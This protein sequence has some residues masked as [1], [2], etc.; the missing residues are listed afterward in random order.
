MSELADT[1]FQNTSDGQRQRVLLASAICREPEILLLDEPTSYLDIRYKLD[2][3]GR[4][5]E[6]A[7]ERGIAVVMSLHELEI[8]M[9][10]SDHVIAIGNGKVLR[11][12]S[13]EEIFTEDFI[14]GLY[15][16]EG[17]DTALLGGDPW[18]RSTESGAAGSAAAEAEM[19]V[20]K[21]KRGTRVIMIQGT[22]SNAG[23]SV[24]AAGLCRIF[25]QDGYRVAPFKSQNMALNSC[26]TEEGLEMGRAQV[27]QAECA[28]IRPRVCMNPILLKP[29]DD[30][31]SQVI[32]N[33][34]VVGNM[35]A[36]EYFRRKKEFI[37]KIREA[38]EELSEDMDIIV[39]EGAGSPVE[40]NLKRDDI[41]NMGLAEMID[42]PVLL[43]GDI[44]RGGIFAQILGTLDLLTT[45]ERARVK[46]VIVNKFRGD[47]ALFADGIGIL[48][49]RG[50][51]RV[52][53]V[54]P[55]MDVHLDDEDSLSE[56]FKPVS[57]GIVDIAVIRFPHISNFTDPDT[58]E[59]LPEVSVRYV[60][61]PEALLSPDLILLPGTKNTIGDLRWLRTSGLAERICR[62]A[63][64][65]LPVI[66]ICGGYQMLGRRISDPDH[67]ECG[68]E[69]AGLDL[70]PADTVLGSEKI[71][72][73]FHGT[74]D[75]AT[76]MLGDLCGKRVSGYEI[77]MGRTAVDAGTTP[78]TSGGTGCC[79]DNI[80]GS[81]IH[82]LFDE[83][84]IT[85]TL[86]GALAG[87]KGKQVDMRNLLDYA[88][89]KETQYDL[90]AAHLREH[91][92]MDRIYEILGIQRGAPGDGT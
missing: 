42:A 81:Y 9:R 8:A 17:M 18:L 51:T 48:E 49:E 66:G 78:F 63:A 28:G 31:G 5:R 83:K 2:I 41:V 21:E 65:G 54:I 61:S 50:K 35:R 12:G 91:L 80:Y 71:R 59:Q 32:V 67:A 77:H 55:W 56:R 47:P 64:A 7:A 4:I 37:P 13:C 23:K 74:I 20:R 58:F 27:M 43:A 11:S 1:Y 62:E 36:A 40:M 44:D 60:T 86:I 92:D 89:Y 3:L 34:R 72:T 53:G 29:T 19:S 68:G 39:V 88:A 24:I 30:T 76:G 16:I 33:G 52:L 45:A 38:F 84:E 70:L 73:L 69:E 82:G 46:G 6:L 14:R 57:P 10:I 90:L 25:H 75:G 15:H 87:R 26:V 79:R 22:M 85:Q